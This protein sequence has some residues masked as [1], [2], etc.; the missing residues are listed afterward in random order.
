MRGAGVRLALAALA[1]LLACALEPAAQDRFYRIEVPA[2]PAVE[3]TTPVLA[4]TLLVRR[5]RSDALTGGARLVYRDTTGDPHVQRFAYQHWVE[6][7]T[8]MVQRE[9]A[10]W[11]RSAGLAE[12]VV[13]PDLRT[14]WDYV[15]SGRLHRMERVTGSGGAR[16]V[17]ELELALSREAD[18][19]VLLLRRYRRERPVADGAPATAVAAYQLALGEIFGEFAADARRAGP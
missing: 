15:L 17:V 7:P 16:V 4:G 6:S 8:T 3:G 19:A 11:L 13:T 2:P 12:Q 5:P 14:S 1:P 18:Y 9:L 10:A